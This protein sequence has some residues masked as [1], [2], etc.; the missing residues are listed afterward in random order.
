LQ[1]TLKDGDLKMTNATGLNSIQQLLRQAVYPATWVLRRLKFLPK[2]VVIGVLLLIPLIFVAWLQYR[3]TTDDIEFNRYERLGMNY[4]EPL[5]DYINAQQRHWVAAVA[6]AS[7]ASAMAPVEAASAD[8]V[9]RLEK[10]IDDVDASIGATLQ[11]TK[12]WTETKAAWAVAVSA[13]GVAA[14]D[15]AHADAVG[16]TADLTVN[17]VANYSK[18]ILDPDLDSYWLMD[19]V[20]VKGPMLGIQIAQQTTK[21]LQPSINKEQYIYDIASAQ[22]AGLSL[23][24]DTENVNLKTAMKETKNF[25][26]NPGIA[27][28]LPGPLAELAGCG[29][30]VK[31]RESNRRAGRSC[32]CSKCS[33]SCT[34]RNRRHRASR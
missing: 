26:N 22:S 32:R 13:S 17:F 10:L 1:L 12:R 34:N 27:K 7:G 8:E 9:A 16:I 15:K 31:V 30:S 3:G 24:G 23:L 25:G 5:H 14:I 28:N 6:R 21:A 18:L 11:T 2:F 33:W 29:D 4:I 20:T 19:V